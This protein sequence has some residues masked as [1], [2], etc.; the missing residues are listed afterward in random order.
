MGRM[1]YLLQLI[2]LSGTIVLIGCDTTKHSKND[3]RLRRTPVDNCKYL[4]R[5]ASGNAQI[6][7]EKNNVVRSQV[8]DSINYEE[9]K[10]VSKAEL[11]Q[12]KTT[13]T[14]PKHV[15][16]PSKPKKIINIKPKSSQIKLSNI[17]DN[18]TTRADRQKML[19]EKSKEAQALLDKSKTLAQDTI[20]AQP[21]NTVLTAPDQLTAQASQ[22]QTQHQV[23]NIQDLPNAPTHQHTTHQPV[24]AHT[25]PI[26][27]H[28]SDAT[29]VQPVPTVPNP[30]AH[31]TTPMPLTPHQTQP[32]ATAIESKMPI[33]HDVGVTHS[34]APTPT[35][36][37][38]TAPASIHVPAL[39]PTTPPAPSP[40]HA[41]APTN[42][43]HQKPGLI[44]ELEK[45]L[46]DLFGKPS[47]NQQTDSVNSVVPSVPNNIQPYKADHK[48]MPIPIP[49]PQN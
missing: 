32:N 22:L 12:V 5:Q 30:S 28:P 46:E 16:K 44:K 24:L 23:P 8:T 26:P 43:E 37:P 7:E 19:D 4:K 6:V 3:Y 35:P 17:P 42:Q 18:K 10:P 45:D 41:P 21:V 1:K 25:P 40:T 29:A 49:Q 27:Q 39:A 15:P 9:F 11:E 31:T 34:N 47:H 33:P 48:P 36:T 38:V 13:K 14:T 2:A 20:A